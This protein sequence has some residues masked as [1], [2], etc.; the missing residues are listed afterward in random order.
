MRRGDEDTHS[1][2]EPAGSGEPPEP[3]T[4]IWLLGRFRLEVDGRDFARRG[5]AAAWE[6]VGF[7]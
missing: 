2:A 5:A 3:R 4:R 7:P 6:A 1:A